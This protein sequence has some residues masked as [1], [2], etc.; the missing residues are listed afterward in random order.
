MKVFVWRNNRR[1]H[2]WSM[3][4]EPNINVEL[5]NDAIAIVMAEDLTQAYALLEQQNQGW[6]VED[7]KRLSPKVFDAS[8]P[9]VVFTELRGE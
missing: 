9:A 3:F 4:D 8:Q 7:L 6:V 2:S 1:F 5:Y